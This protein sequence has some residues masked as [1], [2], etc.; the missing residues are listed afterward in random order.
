MTRT[1]HEQEKDTVDLLGSIGRADLLELRQIRQRQ[2]DGASRERPDPQKI[3]PGQ[4]VAEF[5]TSC[6]L[7]L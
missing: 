7:K 5:N 2:T 4:P 3:A 6:T 1:T